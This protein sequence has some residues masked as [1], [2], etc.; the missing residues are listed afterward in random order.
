MSNSLLVHK[1]EN[2]DSLLSL[3]SLK[4]K[5]SNLL[6]N[7]HFF[8]YAH[9]PCLSFLISPHFGASLFLSLRMLL[10]WDIIIL[11]KVKCMKIH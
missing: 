5:I 7:V 1:T 4:L 2:N 8:N 3:L 11:T 6:N 9:H 10:K